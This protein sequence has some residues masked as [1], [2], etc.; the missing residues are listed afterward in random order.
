EQVEQTAVGRFHG[1]DDVAG[2]APD[3]VDADQ[4]GM[5][6]AADRLDGAQFLAGAGTLRAGQELESSHLPIDAGFPDL[7]KGTLP[8]PAAQA[9]AGE[10]FHVLL[11]DGRSGRGRQ[12]YLL[13]ECRRGMWGC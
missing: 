6:E 1:N 13:V 3:A 4:V 8:E 2:L 11:Q 12:L 10:R 5:V 9:V 7:G